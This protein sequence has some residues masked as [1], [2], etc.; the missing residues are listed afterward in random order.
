MKNPVSP[1]RKIETVRLCSEAVAFECARNIIA[2]LMAIRVQQIA[3]ETS[4]ATPDADFLARLRVEYFRLDKESTALQ[5]H[6]QAG[7]A[8]IHAEYGAIVRA[9]LLYSDLVPVPHAA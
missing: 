3:D 2:D 6:D 4:K 1:V 5:I 9:W 7:V 8:R